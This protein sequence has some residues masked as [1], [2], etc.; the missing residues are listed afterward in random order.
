LSSNASWPL[1]S[2]LSTVASTPTSGSAGY[3]SAAQVL[4]GRALIRPLRRNG[5]SD[6]ASATGKRRLEA[7]MGQLFG[8]RCDS[9]RQ[10][11]ELPWRTDF[12]SRLHLIRHQNND[13]VLAELARTYVVEALERWLPMV[14]IKAVTVERP[15][16]NVVRLSISYVVL[17]RGT[18]QVLAADTLS[19]PL[20]TT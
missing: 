1:S 15:E 5:I 9:A 20:Q 3:A 14:R 4:V 6:F 7:A 10:Q 16:L 17:A 12:G 2:T 11:G 19:V 8:T 18:D 13:V